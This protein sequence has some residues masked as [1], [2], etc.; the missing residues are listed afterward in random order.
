MQKFFVRF[1]ATFVALSFVSGCGPSLRHANFVEQ[2][3]SAFRIVAPSEISLSDALG[4]SI[5]TDRKWSFHEAATISLDGTNLGETPASRQKVIALKLGAADSWGSVSLPFEDKSKPV[6]R[7]AWSKLKNGDTFIAG[8]YLADSKKGPPLNRSWIVPVSGG[9]VRPG[10]VMQDPRIDAAATTLPDGK[11]LVSGGYQKNYRHPLTSCELFDP[12]S[13]AFTP[14]G[15]LSVPRSQHGMIE[16]GKSKVIIVCGMSS[17]QFADALYSST[18]VVEILDCESK[19]S[20]VIGKSH[21]ARLGPQLLKVRKTSVLLFDG[22][23]EDVDAAGQDEQGEVKA[24]ELF[25]ELPNQR[26]R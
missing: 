14:C 2:L 9:P 21:Y 19:K 6:G 1:S 11:V 22:I 10:P 26:H 17:E 15:N 24:A 8:G 7:F 13:N 25:D 18:R 12:I 5:S 4:K 16:I 20:E 3:P 23:A